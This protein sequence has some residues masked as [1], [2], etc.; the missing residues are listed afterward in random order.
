MKDPVCI[1]GCGRGFHL[2]IG[3]R[4]MS[5]ERE[6]YDL[7]DRHAAQERLSLRE[8]PLAERCVMPAWLE[9]L[10]NVIGYAGFI[11]IATWHKSSDEEMMNRCGPR[12][13]G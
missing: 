10:I 5:T 1:Y 2:P 11:A 8:I 3:L 12:D 6:P 4:A 13:R 7:A 9:I